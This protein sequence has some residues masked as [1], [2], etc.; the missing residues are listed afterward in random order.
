MADNFIDS[1]KESLF[2]ISKQLVDDFWSEKKQI[3]PKELRGGQASL[4]LRLNCPPRAYA[5]Y[6]EWFTIT[7]MQVDGKSL[8]RNKYLK[9]SHPYSYDARVFWEVSKQERALAKQYEQYFSMIRRAVADLKAMSQSQTAFSRRLRAFNK[10]LAAK[11][12]QETEPAN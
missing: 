2:L 5:F 4:G 10:V 1:N 11:Y 6:V 9:R 8:P 3:P 12:I 7:F